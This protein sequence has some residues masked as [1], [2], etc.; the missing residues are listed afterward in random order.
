MQPAVVQA[1]AVTVLLVVIPAILGFEWLIR[2][3]DRA[4]S[5]GRLRDTTQDAAQAQV[6]AWKAMRMPL[7]ASAAL[8]TIVIV[9]F[10]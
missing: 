6:A 10:R 8:A 2:K 9:S 1:V 4:I 5:E 3:V 7:A